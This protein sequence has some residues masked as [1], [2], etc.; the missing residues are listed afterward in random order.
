MLPRKK[1]YEHE[2]IELSM[3]SISKIPSFLQRMIKYFWK[4][5]IPALMASY[6]VTHL[7][8]SMSLYISQVFQK[9]DY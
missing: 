9:S 3:A 5:I 1:I 2:S 7:Q 4:S 8:I 6:R